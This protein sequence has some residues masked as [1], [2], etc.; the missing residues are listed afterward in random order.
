MATPTLTTRGKPYDKPAPPVITT[1][2][3][4]DRWNA[5]LTAMLTLAVDYGRLD[6]LATKRRQ[7]CDQNPWHELHDERHAAMWLTTQER[8]EAGGKMMD[9]ADE[10]AHIQSQLPQHTIDGLS[11]LMGHPL[12]PQVG[13]RW[14]LTAA[15][16]Q[17]ADIFDI[18]AVVMMELVAESDEREQEA[19]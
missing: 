13:Q 6:T 2:Q 17:T 10:L 15:R 18:A 5:A 1:A 8:N 4:I 9:L 3:L 11:A 19:A 12:Y 7:W 16:M 14:A